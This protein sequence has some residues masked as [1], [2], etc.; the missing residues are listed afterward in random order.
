V[1]VADRKDK[2]V[3]TKD[4]SGNAATLG[5]RTLQFL[6]EYVRNPQ[7]A[8]APEIVPHGG[9]IHEPTKV[10]L[11]S[12]HPTAKI[13]YTSDG[14]MPTTA[15]PAYSGPITVNPGTTLQ[16]IAVKP[17]LRPSP[18][19][20]AAFRPC[21]LP[22]PVITTS[23]QS[24]TAKVG[25]PFTITFEARSSAPVQWLIAGKVG[26]TCDLSANPPRPIPAFEIEA[27]T[28]RLTDK[29][30]GPGT[31]VFIVVASVQDGTET[32][33]DA[34]PVVVTIQE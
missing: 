15:S 32:L 7:F 27:A 25:E 10:V 30:S 8:T 13:H 34:R 16:A 23:A 4:K 24:F 22:P 19:A 28:G 33:V 3:M 31:C 29:P 5:Q 1:G 12:V 6:D 26:T 11:R 17:G 14:S 9:P 20:T 2:P 18:L 21:K